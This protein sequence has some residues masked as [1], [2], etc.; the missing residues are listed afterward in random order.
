MVYN[1]PIA[2]SWGPLATSDINTNTAAIN[3]GNTSDS[4]KQMIN[5]LLIKVGAVVGGYTIPTGIAFIYFRRLAISNAIES[6]QIIQSMLSN[7]V[8]IDALGLRGM[9]IAGDGEVILA[10]TTEAEALGFFEEALVFL[11]NL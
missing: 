1:T 9:T 6:Y 10:D 8:T 11:S 5:N 4:T 2:L 7:G 3:T